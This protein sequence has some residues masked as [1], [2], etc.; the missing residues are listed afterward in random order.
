[1]QHEFLASIPVHPEI[2]GSIEAG[3]KAVVSSSDHAIIVI[4]SGG[5]DFPIWIFRT[6]RGNMGEGHGVLGDADTDSGHARILPS[7]Y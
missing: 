5:P 6:E 3:C 2:C 4:K 1:M 7:F